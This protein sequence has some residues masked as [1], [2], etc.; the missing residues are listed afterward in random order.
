MPTDRDKP[1]DEAQ[2]LDQ[3]NSHP[4]SRHQNA[5]HTE[6]TI[7]DGL[8]EN[9]TQRVDDGDNEKVKTALIDAPDSDP[10]DLLETIEDSEWGS[11]DAGV[12]EIDENILK[13]SRLR[14]VLVFALFVFIAAWSV[15][16][17]FDQF[18][19]TSA[20]PDM[21]LEWVGHHLIVSGAG[22]DLADKVFAGDEIVSVNDEQIDA[23]V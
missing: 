16:D 22:P 12:E 6:S 14:W 13:P 3:K 9:S 18:S 21:S 1:K 19:Q 17:V 15:L 4:A 11:P 5:F 2:R 7:S 20:P 23:P 8:L 10:T